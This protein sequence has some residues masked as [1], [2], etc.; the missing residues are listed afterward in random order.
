M[1]NNETVQTEEQKPKLKKLQIDPDAIRRM[2]DIVAI[3]SAMGWV[4]EEQEEGQLKT[5]YHLCNDITEVET[6]S[7]TESK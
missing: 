6:E 2:E 7:E 1:E 3:I 5:I 4:L